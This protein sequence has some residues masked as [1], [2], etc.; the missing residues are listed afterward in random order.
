MPQL[1]N[2]LVSLGLKGQNA[3]LSTMKKIQKK[4][5]DLSKKPIEVSTKIKPT[6]AAPKKP[7]E[8]TLKK[9]AKATP[10]KPAESGGASS[11]QTA[12]EQSAARE[13]KKFSRVVDKFSHGVQNFAGAT[14]SFDPTAAISSVT[15]AIGTSLSGI[16]VLGVS[17]GRMPEGI[18]AIAAST[19][20]MA[21]NSVDMAR[22][23]TAA[24][25][26]LTIRNA[27]AQHYGEN[28]TRESP[29]S[30]NERALFIDAVSGSMGRIQRPLAD[31][32][33]NLLNTKDARALARVSAGDWESTG[34]DKGWML[35]QLSSSFQGLPPSVRQRL[36]A[37]LLKNYAG[38]M[39]NLAPGQAKTQRSAAAW[40]NMEEDQT[41]EL[42]NRAA[43]ALPLAQ[44]LN[45]MQVSLYNT[46]IGMTKTIDKIITKM[47]ELASSLPRLETTINNLAKNPNMR[48]LREILDRLSISR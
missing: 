5:S 16:S 23:T 27:A 24:F 20:M 8:S 26:Q 35:G 22:Q 47:E 9:Q 31:A 12:Q 28:I 45:D 39:Q 17:L 4:G 41:E 37:S 30:R 7:A 46:G 13:N 33:N 2:Y 14:A 3:V 36:Q 11:Q 38:E 25:H 48:S 42:A 10:K 34:T 44:K 21:R 29:L 1:D 15:S 32:I 6:K 18:A 19:L 43:A 40:V